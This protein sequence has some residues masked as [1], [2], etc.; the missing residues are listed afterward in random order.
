MPPADTSDPSRRRPSAEERRRDLRRRR[1]NALLIFVAGVAAIAGFVVW[2]GSGDDTG[3]ATDEVAS[4]PVLQV[5]ARAPKPVLPAPKTAELAVTA[6]GGDG[7][8]MRV[9]ATPAGTAAVSGPWRPAAKA[10]PIPAGVKPLLEAGPIP[11]YVQVR[12]DSGGTARSTSM[13]LPPTPGDGTAEIVRS[14]STTRPYVALVFDDGLDQP[15]V[16]RIIDILR[17]QKAGGTFC[18]NGI[19]V[20]L[21]TPVLAR[22]VHAAV[23]DGVITMCSHGWGHRTSTTSSESEATTDLAN[24]ATTDRMIGVSSVPFYRPPYGAISPGIE[25]AAGKLGYRWIVMWDVDPSDYEKPSVPT[26]TRRVV[27]ESRKGSIV[28][29]HA[30]PTTADALPG[31]LSGLRKKKLRA[32]TL[33]AMFGELSS[34]AGSGS[35]STTTA[36]ATTGGDAP[37]VPGAGD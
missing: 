36:P 12:D 23:A 32:V 14:V 22:K 17:K 13:L 20:K 11:G 37:P 6:T 33:T 9:V 1:R 7:L 28:V 29:L 31:I 4:A 26:L 18:L 25:K 16:G 10:L 27:D 3:A 34:A 2:A 5:V 19:N 30:I 15:A 24:N 21:W 35:A 8:E